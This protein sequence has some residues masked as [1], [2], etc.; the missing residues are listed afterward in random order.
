IATALAAGELDRAEELARGI[1]QPK[2]QAGA[3]AEVAAAAATRATPAELRRA[4]RITA[5]LLT[6]PSW[7]RAMGVLATLAPGAV[8]AVGVALL[9]V[10]E[11]Q[12]VDEGAAPA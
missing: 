7:P 9:A 8:Q 1:A 6:T 5:T 3:L 10:L 12:P 2:P 4:R 11:E